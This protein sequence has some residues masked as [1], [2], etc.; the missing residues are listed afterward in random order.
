M[1]LARRWDRNLH[2]DHAPSPPLL[3]QIVFSRLLPTPTA[4]ML[5]FDD[6][7]RLSYLKE[8]VDDGDLTLEEVKEIYGEN[9]NSEGGLDKQGFLK[10]Q[11]MIEDLFE[12]EDDDEMGG[13]GMRAADR[14]EAGSRSRE[15]QAEKRSQ[16]LEAIKKLT[17][18]DPAGLNCDENADDDVLELA[19]GLCEMPGNI[20]LST[21]SRI[22]PD[23]ITGDWELL[24]TN[25][26]MFQFNQGLTGLA[27][28]M[29][30]GK[31]N[32]LVQSL[33]SKSFA[34]D[35]DY[36]E[37]I[38]VAGGQSIIANVDGDWDLKS[39]AS[40]LTGEPTVIMS[41]EPNTVRYGPSTTKAD[42]WKSVRSMNLLDMSYL[43]D[44]IRIMRGN[45][46]V[47]TI[48]IFKKLS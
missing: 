19:N 13:E 14:D 38:D 28:T 41:V 44:K 31:F 26:G 35:C 22:D 27:T 12:D 37:T 11:Q 48:F 3:L 9:C 47:R 46:S 5:S 15:L 4:T 32:S 21:R 16:L 20:V 8:Y 17:A 33:K 24:F 6:L 2:D 42:H 39:T 45:T 36:K 43:D 23:D 40:L 18:G 10:F 25:S 30:Q 7:A 29:P 1:I 34:K